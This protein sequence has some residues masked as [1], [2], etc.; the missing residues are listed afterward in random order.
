MWS[1]VLFPGKGR[2]QD[3]Q[4]GWEKLP[5]QM[6]HRAWRWSAASTGAGGLLRDAR[7]AIPA[8]RDAGMEDEVGPYSQRERNV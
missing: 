7:V 3:S 1:F 6:V 2:D 4:N 5:K 8:G